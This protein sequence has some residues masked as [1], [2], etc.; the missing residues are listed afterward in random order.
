MKVY[1]KDIG[2]GEYRVTLRRP[3]GRPDDI[4]E[5]EVPQSTAYLL[6][7]AQASAEALQES[8]KTV[9]NRKGDGALWWDNDDGRGPGGGG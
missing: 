2:A 9:W 6:L 4:K 5:Y 3:A 7:A 1:V 8:L